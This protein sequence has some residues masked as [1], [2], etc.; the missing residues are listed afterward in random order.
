MWTRKQVVSF[1]SVASVTWI[2]FFCNISSS[3]LVY[4]IPLNLERAELSRLFLYVP[5]LVWY[6]LLLC[7]D[8]LGIHGKWF[9]L[10]QVHFSF[11]RTSEMSSPLL[12]ASSPKSYRVLLNELNNLVFNLFHFFT[13]F[14]STV[15]FITNLFRFTLLKIFWK[16]TNFFNTLQKASF[17]IEVT[18]QEHVRWT[19]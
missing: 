9:L 5:F 8:C 17:K 19:A 3:F 10:R 14:K 11:L 7:L 4:S 13:F 12:N 15:G 6:H 2:V 1:P 16:I 18:F